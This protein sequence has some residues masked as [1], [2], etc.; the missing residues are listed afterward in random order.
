MFRADL[1]FTSAGRTMYEVASLGVPCVCLC[2]NDREL[3]HLFGNAENGFMNLGLGK[4]LS[5]KEIIH[6]IEKLL[7]DYNLR[8]EMNKK[9]LAIDLKHGFE[10]MMK[11]VKEKY[12]EFEKDNNL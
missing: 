6:S 3:T 4:N 1:I 11:V 9:M 12:K 2:Q 5:E 10:N 8:S 7:A